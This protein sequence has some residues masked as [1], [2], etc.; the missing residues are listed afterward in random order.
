MK[1][2][3]KRID[4]ELPLP[5]YQTAGAVAFDLC[6]RVDTEIAPG[7]IVPVPANLIIRV[8]EGYAFLIIARSSLP[9]KKGLMLPNSVGVFDQDY[10]GPEDEVKVLLYNFKNQTAKIERGERLAQGLLVKI[11]KA[12][13]EETDEMNNANRGG[14]GSTG[15]YK[16]SL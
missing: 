11:E 3:I 9:G 14:F 7:E 16:T 6:A 10:W 8:P 5:Q 4:K 15:G 2:K 1:V 13:L 12:E